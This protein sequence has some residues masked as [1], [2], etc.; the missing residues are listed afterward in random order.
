[1][2]P[3]AFSNPILAATW[4]TLGVVSI[5]LLASR[6][7]ADA[8]PGRYVIKTET[9]Y[10]TKTK[11]TWQQSPATSPFS[12]SDAGAYCAGLT[13]GGLD[14]RLP[15]VKELETLVDES[16][17]NPAIDKTAFPDTPGKFF[18]TSSS[19][20]SFPDQAWTVDFNR[21]GCN[22]FPV[23]SMELVRCVH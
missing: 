14:W 12:H 22:F 7:F 13:V 1:M 23:T 9:V 17:T 5:A 18:W 6:G 20:A 8:K 11:L 3:K 15:S 21:G 2:I 16:R 19:V 10:D 4:T